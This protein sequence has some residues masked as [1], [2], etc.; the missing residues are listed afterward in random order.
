MHSTWF[1]QFSGTISDGCNI[2]GMAPAIIRG[3]L[4]EA[5]YGKVVPGWLLWRLS[6]WKAVCRWYVCVSFWWERIFFNSL[7]FVICIFAPMSS[8][9][10]SWS[11]IRGGSIGSAVRMSCISI[12]I[13]RNRK[14]STLHHH[15][16]RREPLP[17]TRENELNYI[18]KLRCHPILSYGP[19]STRSL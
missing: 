15:N 2:N 9:E 19:N 4:E 18:A 13:S 1:F 6:E 5:V 12:S 8:E 16:S 14:L 10:K 11:I 17:T 3:K 7:Q